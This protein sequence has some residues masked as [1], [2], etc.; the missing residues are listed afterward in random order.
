MR[1]SKQ[2]IP[3]LREVPQEAEIPSHKLMLRSGLIRKL[4]GGLYTFLPLGLRSLR[5]VERIIREEMDRAGALEILMP[6]LQPQEIW[7]E[8]GRFEVLR[9]VMFKMRDRQDRAMVLG[10]THE[11]VVT[12]LVAG[13]INSYRQLSRNFYQIQTKFRDEIR[14][15]FGLMRAKEFIMKDAYSFDVGWDEADV[16]YKAMYDAYVRIFHRCGLRTKV[17]EADT[18]AMG[19][20]SSHEFMVLA[21]AGEDGLVECEKCSY[22]ANLEQAEGRVTKA[23]VFGD[24]QAMPEKVETPDKK[25]IDQVSSFLKSKPSQFIKTLIYVSGGQPVAVLVPG[26]RDVNEIKLR[27]L[28]GNDA[29]LADPDIIEKVTGAP[30]GFAGPVG[31]NIRIIADLWLKGARGMISGANEINH[32]IRNINL[33]RD[34]AHVEFADVVTA[35]GKDGC[36]RCDGVLKGARGIEV[37]HV[38]KLGTKY[39]EKL[40]ATYL[41]AAG[42]T[43]TI[44]MGCYGIGVTRTLQSVIEQS[45]DDQG[46]IWPISIAPYE[47]TIMAVN[48][49]HP[50]SV[51]LVEK[52]ADG[53]IAAGI[54]VLY[55]DRDERPGVKFKDVDL[56]GTP[57]RV[58]VGE[59]S[60]AKGEVEIKVR[61]TGEMTGV[62]VDRALEEILAKIQG[63][64]AELFPAG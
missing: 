40:G 44:V 23:L 24:E 59:R 43:K 60:L 31:L 38:F 15:R 22:A 2:F 48:A 36:P 63:L 28:I 7:E 9:H 39:S 57:L 61:K 58:S 6:A 13:E 54:D 27:R 3:T 20:K 47:V 35:A 32:H 14:P 55:D 8:S 19:G 64:K 51:A 33:E 21:D 11:E 25:T 50:E 49:T 17:V 42:E 62:P 26:H 46:I 53:L 30:T 1:W 56:I 41:D 37:G 52:L 45:H 5:K 18:G 29:A 4:S 10:P 16:S 34:V 12:G